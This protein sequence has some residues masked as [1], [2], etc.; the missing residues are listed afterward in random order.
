MKDVKVGPMMYRTASGWRL[1]ARVRAANA[2][3]GAPGTLKWKRIEDGDHATDLPKLKRLRDAWKV[4]AQQIVDGVPAG[5]VAPKGT[6]AADLVIYQRL[7]QYVAKDDAYKEEFGM[8]LKTLIARLE[9]RGE[10]PGPE[11]PRLTI[12]MQEWQVILGQLLQER[13]WAADTF[14][15][16]LGSLKVF[17]N[18]LADPNKAEPNPVSK[19][20]RFTGPRAEAKNIDYKVIVRILHRLAPTARTKNK[21]S[22]QTEQLVCRLS[23]EG[24]SNVKL[25][26]V[27]GV[28]E[29]AV[30]KLLRRGPK[31]KARE[32]EVIEHALWVQAFTGIRPVQWDMLK[33]TD[34]D[35]E[36]R[37]VKVT[38]SKKGDRTFPKELDDF[39]VQVLQAAIDAQAL[40]PYDRSNAR[41]MWYEACEAEGLPKPWPYPYQLKHSYLTEAMTGTPD[42]MAVMQN[43]GHRN[44]SSLDRYTE[45]AK[46]AVR[47]R[48]A[49]GFGVR[50]RTVLAPKPS[51]GTAGR[52]EVVVFEKPEEKSQGVVD[53]AGLEPANLLRVKQAL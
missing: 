43:S 38:A 46:Q 9:T 33:P 13:K 27:A 21:M 34:F 37:V 22:F 47:R 53:A 7:P 29:T 45:A 19:I 41:D 17:Y 30:R 32:T 23:K 11:R 18:G 50:M 26:T 35:A 20:K 25:A 39:G 36:A 5:P 31:D 16:W 24:V 51:P 4:E 2:P 48:V 49:D 15:K 6:I 42:P 44:L 8:H 40:Q 10:T 14:N 12:E 3:K 52:G 1:G 28:S